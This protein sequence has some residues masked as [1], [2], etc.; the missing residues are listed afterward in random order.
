MANLKDCP[1]FEVF[2][3]YYTPKEAWEK[4]NHL[5]PKDKVVWEAFML[6]SN[7][8]KSI[9]NL[10]EM[11]V[12]VIGNTEWDFLKETPEHDLIISNPPFSNP[13]KTLCLKKLVENDKPFIIIMNSMNLFSVYFNDIFKDT[14]EH[15]QVIYPKGKIHFEK[16]M[17]DGTTELKT[18]TSFY[19]VYVAYKM[20]LPNCK[21]YLD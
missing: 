13:L 4:I 12:N 7:Q 18:K 11:K 17:E 8:S 14:R 10:K 3:D 5:I 15:L 9:K 20:K 16:L 2:D 19:C 1:K 21:L 6:G